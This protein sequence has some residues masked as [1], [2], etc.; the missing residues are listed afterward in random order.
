MSGPM[1]HNSMALIC[2]ESG[3]Y[4]HVK[5]WF[6]ICLYKQAGVQPAKEFGIWGPIRPGAA[7]EFACTS[8]PLLLYLSFLSV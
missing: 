6:G 3:L 5:V 2:R 7:P 4:K 1:S 8:T